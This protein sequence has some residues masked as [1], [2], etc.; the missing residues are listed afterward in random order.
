[1]KIQSVFMRG[2]A[3]TAIVLAASPIIATASFATA[4][5]SSPGNVALTSANRALGASWTESPT[6]AYTFV[7]TAKASGHATRSCTTHALK[8]SI[9]A[10]ANGVTYSVTVTAKNAGGT[11]APSTAVTAKVGVPS[12]PLSVHATAGKGSA[13]V[14]WA[15]PVASGVA[16]I[17]GYTATAMPGS[18]TC[19][20]ASTATTPAARHCVISGLTKGVKYSVTVVATNAN[21]SSPSSKAATVTSK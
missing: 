5:P 17:T 6:G 12:A 3:A 19:S 2:A 4:A 18:F 8:C 11:S 20:T 14:M 7:A 9:V 13:S 15:P 21:G 1:M 10:L 16:A